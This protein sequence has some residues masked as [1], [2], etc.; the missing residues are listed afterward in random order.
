M[1]IGG[2]GRVAD[3]FV[4]LFCCVPI[5]LEDFKAKK[6]DS[7]KPGRTKKET[8]FCMSDPLYSLKTCCKKCMIALGL[9]KP[10]MPKHFKPSNA[11]QQ[12]HQKLFVSPRA[13]LKR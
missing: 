4:L 5:A 10:G 2:S 13:S 1:G 6:V 12:R 8:P 9:E 3:L 11:G 7:G